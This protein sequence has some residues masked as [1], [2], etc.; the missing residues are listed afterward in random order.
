M[1][2]DKQF[3]SVSEYQDALSKWMG[4]DD[5]VDK[6]SSLPEYQQE[7]L[8]AEGLLQFI[9]QDRLD[10]AMKLKQFESM[11]GGVEDVR[12]VAIK[13]RDL[14]G[15][16][17][18]PEEV[19]NI[20]PT[21]AL[22]AFKQSPEIQSYL[23]YKQEQGG[24]GIPEEQHLRWDEF[25]DAGTQAVNEYNFYVSEARRRGVVPKHNFESFTKALAKSRVTPEE[26]AETA[27]LTSEVADPEKAKQAALKNVKSPNF[28][29]N[30]FKEIAAV[31]GYGLK[32]LQY[33]Q[34]KVATLPK[35]QQTPERSKE[36]EREYDSAEV[37]KNMESRLQT[38]VGSN[39]A[40]SV[41]KVTKADTGEKGW[42]VNEGTKDEFFVRAK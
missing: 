13:R 38:L 24:L 3:R 1:M 6:F 40:K 2:P 42:V 31:P 34:A 8:G 32:R 21:E 28:A 12:S 22:T 17:G 30:I 15:I 9:Q 10:K 41:R 27:R 25:R 37:N 18:D 39:Y 19:I 16:G 5:I 4:G 7:A 11:Y 23:F 20:T 33:V 14:P 26:K 35:E 29:P 36:I